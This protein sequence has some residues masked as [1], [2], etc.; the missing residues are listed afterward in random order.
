[1]M[2]A[3]ARCYAAMRALYR[4][5]AYDAKRYATPAGASADAMSAT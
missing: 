4:Y 1:M 3:A 2:L 5:A